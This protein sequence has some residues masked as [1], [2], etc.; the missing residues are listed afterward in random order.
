MQVR[1]PQRSCCWRSCSRFPRSGLVC[2]RGGGCTA[3]APNS[4]C[5]VVGPPYRTIRPDSS[6]PCPLKLSRYAGA[7]SSV[8]VS[9]V[10]LSRRWNTASRPF[11]SV[12]SHAEPPLLRSPGFK[13][14]HLWMRWARERM[15]RPREGITRRILRGGACGTAA[16]H[17]RRSG[18]LVPPWPLPDGKPSN[19]NRTPSR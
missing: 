14:L 11:L 10:S 1:V 12:C 19:G 13:G 6:G 18:L 2:L 16:S 7:P 17:C 5:V 4:V 15:S 3:A 9:F 8:F